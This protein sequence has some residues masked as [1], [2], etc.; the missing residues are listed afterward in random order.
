MNKVAHNRIELRTFLLTASRK[1]VWTGHVVRIA[2][3]RREYRVVLVTETARCRGEDNSKMDL[4][5]M[6]KVWVRLN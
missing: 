4:K 2:D 3:S 6:G 5:E 1:G